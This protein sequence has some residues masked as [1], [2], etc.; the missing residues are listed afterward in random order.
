MLLWLAGC[1][2]P[3][4]VEQYPN[5]QKMIGKSKS[6]LLACAGAPKKQEPWNGATLFHYYREAPILEESE[7]VGRGS[8]ATARHGCWATAVI[9]QDRI[10]DVVYEFVP[11]TFDASNDCEA[12]FDSCL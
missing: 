6:A 5:Q 1:A 8:F 2:G 10:T 3:A 11:H 4:R 9:E 12:I 7:P